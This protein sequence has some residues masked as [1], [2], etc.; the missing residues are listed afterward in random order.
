M[1]P[2]RLLKQTGVTRAWS[3]LI[4]WLSCAR[5][6]QK[7][8]KMASAGEGNQTES[9]VENESSRSRNSRY[10]QDR[11]INFKKSLFNSPFSAA[12]SDTEPGR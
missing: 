11:L 3:P 8:R 10:K 1:A 6:T 5:F 9:V 7:I 2:R 4:P 12:V